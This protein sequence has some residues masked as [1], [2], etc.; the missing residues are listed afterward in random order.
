MSRFYLILLVFFIGNNGA[1]SQTKI[2][3]YIKFADAQYLKGD[4]YYALQYYKKALEIDSNSIDL[5][6]KYAETFRSYKDYRNAEYYYNKVYK[7]EET[8]LYPNSLLYLALMKKQNGKYNEALKLFKL[9]KRAYAKTKKKYRYKKAKQEFKSCLWAIDYQNNLTK[10]SVYALPE[11]VNSYDAEFVHTVHDGQL[12]FSSLRADSIS[13]KEEVYS[14]SYKTKLFSSLIYDT[15]Y[16]ENKIINDLLI[17]DFNTGNGTFSP[18]GKTYYFSV[19][20]D[21]G[22]NYRCQIWRTD[23]DNGSWSNPI[24]LPGVVN[25]E[26]SNTTMPCYGNLKGKDVLFFSSNRSGGKG[27][28]DIWYTRLNYKGKEYY[29]PKNVRKVNSLDNDICP[30]WDT[31]NQKLY[32]SSSWFPGFG[33]YDIFE[34]LYEGSFTTPKNLKRPINSQANDIYYFNNNDT[35]YFS[36]NRIG[37]MSKKNPTCCSDI[38]TVTPPPIVFDDIIDTAITVEILN[39]FVKRPPVK[40]YFHNDRPNPNSTDTITKLNYLST[41]QSYKGLLQTYKAKYS[42]GLTEQKALEAQEDMEEFFLQ[43]IDRGVKDLDEFSEILLIELKKGGRF[44]LTIQGFASPLAATDYN[45]NL[46]KRRISSYM[47]Y[48]KEYHGGVFLPYL[49]ETASNGGA[50]L[51]EYSP[52]GENTA[53]QQISDNPSDKKKSVYSIR[54]AK[55][56]R[57]EI[58]SV[59]FLKSENTFPLTVPKTVF[60]AKTVFNGQKIGAYFSMVNTS[61]TVVLID[62]IV[63][64]YNDIFVEIDSKTLNPNEAAVVKMYVNTSEIRGINA[65]HIDISLIGYTEKQRLSIISEVIEYQKK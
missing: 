12:I 4:Y 11:T 50:L 22:Y 41:Y 58:Q 3:K 43:Y 23:Y 24:V 7:R 55:E 51:V 49:N 34:S 40:M 10:D 54:A 14:K 6:W 59:S 31:I 2:G 39:H 19:C 38:Y 64:S 25:K 37:S 56:R 20:E 26:G 57:V 61:D 45:V 16:Q 18:D 46:T 1:F 17:E 33:G 63:T 47:N 42:N 32:F 27:G 62:S 65:R 15:V 44:K 60:D 28:M 21:E 36:S 48:L 13:N 9:A 8:R 35:L 30:W 52:Y 29:K 53:D 5:L